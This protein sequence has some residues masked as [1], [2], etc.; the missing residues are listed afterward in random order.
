MPSFILLIVIIDD[1][2]NNTDLLSNDI[3]L[4]P[5][6]LLWFHMTLFPHQPWG[7]PVLRFRE[8]IVKFHLK[9]VTNHITYCRCCIDYV[10]LLFKYSMWKWQDMVMICANE[11]PFYFVVAQGCDK[12]V[13]SVEA[14]ADKPDKLDDITNLQ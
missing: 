14:S 13:K 4:L 12:A 10:M 1:N 9:V 3:I 5:V 2:N 6:L 8:G 7:T 11:W